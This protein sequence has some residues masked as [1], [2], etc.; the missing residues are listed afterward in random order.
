M[1]MSHSLLS[2]NKVKVNISPPGGLAF[3]RQSPT[4]KRQV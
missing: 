2:G 3:L 4:W 1:L